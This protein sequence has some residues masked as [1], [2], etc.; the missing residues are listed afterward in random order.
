MANLIALILSLLLATAGMFGGLAASG[1]PNNQ[2]PVEE[3]T[4]AETTAAETTAAETEPA[5]TAQPAEKETVYVNAPL[6]NV[7]SGPGYEFDVLGVLG[8][9]QEV[10][11][12]GTEG[13]WS[14]ILYN[15][16]EA[17]V[18][19]E[20]LSAEGPA[21]EPETEPATEV[22]EPE[23]E[24]ATE[25]PEPETEP[26]TEAPEPETEPATEAPE[27]ETEPVTQEPE[28]E[29]ATEAPEPETEPATAE[30]EPEEESSEEET[31]EEALTGEPYE[32]ELV[33]FLY[34]NT[35]YAEITRRLD[36]DPTAPQKSIV[37]DL[38]GIYILVAQ[39]NIAPD[40]LLG[41]LN[42][43]QKVEGSPDGVEEYTT[44]DGGMFKITHT[45]S[46]YLAVYLK[47]AEDK[48]AGTIY[49]TIELVS[50]IMPEKLQTVI[51]SMR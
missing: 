47:D 20:Y 27:Q 15:G 1:F 50:G 6:L 16:S 51:S 3:T 45:N 38:D 10:T 41:K 26:A 17:W 11:R 35:V 4:A 43:P 42:D 12:V 21:P 36:D 2:K 37:Y 22:P 33:A 48:A 44:A 28:T 25:A 5:T 23:T 18:V 8:E 30:P 7:R 32:D 34:D 14:K 19:S 46:V 31:T 29:P 49:R 13:T 9:G 24:P 39:S 40:T